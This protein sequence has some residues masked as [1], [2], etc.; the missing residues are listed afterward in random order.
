MQLSRISEKTP[1]DFE[2]LFEKGQRVLFSRDTDLIKAIDNLKTII[3]SKE[4]G[5]P[6]AFQKIDYIDMR[7]GNKIFYKSK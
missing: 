6:Q 2:G 7:F 3:E 5:G 4:F 1:V